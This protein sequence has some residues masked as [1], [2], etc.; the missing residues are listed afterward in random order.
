[1]QIESKHLGIG[2]RRFH[3]RDTEDFYHAVCDSIDTVYPWM[4]WCKPDYSLRDSADWVGSREFLWGA[5]LDYS[6]LIFSVNND[7]ILGGVSLNQIVKEHRVANLGYWVRGGETGKG[8]ATAAAR[9]TLDFG[10]GE[11][12]LNRIEIHIAPKNQASIRVAQKLGA[13]HEGRLRSKLVLHGKP[14]SAESYSLIP[15]DIGL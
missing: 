11:M 2:I 12:G 5:G 3:E 10:F 15:A 8:Y 6:F 1:M 7:R 13:L 14:I 9:L 4:P